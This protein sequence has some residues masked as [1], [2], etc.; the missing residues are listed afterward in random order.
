L[1][2]RVVLCRLEA[3]GHAGEELADDDL[4]LDADDR[5]GGAGH[6]QIGDVGGAAG[7]DALVGG[8]MW[9]GAD[10]R[11]HLPSR[12]PPKATFAGRLGA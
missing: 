7:E 10:D 3:L 12:N 1:Q 4:G 9:V 11:A 2:L 6:P 5:F 8:L